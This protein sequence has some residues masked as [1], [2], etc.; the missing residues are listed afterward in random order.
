MQAL[1]DI[2]NRITA[3]F[4]SNDLMAMGALRGIAARSLRVPDDIAVV[5]FDGIAIGRYT[6]PP[7]TT[8][9]QPVREIVKLATELVLARVME[10]AKSR[11]C[12]VW[13]QTCLFADH[14]ELSRLLKADPATKQSK[15]R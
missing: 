5:G 15:K 4:A 8:M 7:L 10:L 14:V 12:I 2:P 9:A 13:R 1:L 6:L 11:K 3:V